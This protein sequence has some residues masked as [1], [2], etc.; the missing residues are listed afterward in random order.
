MRMSSSYFFGPAHDL[1][2]VTLP[3]HTGRT[4]GS[5]LPTFLHTP[6]GGGPVV[7]EVRANGLLVGRCDYQLHLSAP[8]GVNAGTLLRPETRWLKQV[9]VHFCAVEG[10]ALAG[11]ARA[12]QMVP[13]GWMLKTLAAANQSIWYPQAQIAFSTASDN[14]IPVIQDPTPPNGSNGALGDL[15]VWLRADGLEV[16]RVCEQAWELRFPGRRGVPVINARQLFEQ[17][18]TLGVSAGPEAALY[19]AGRK[20]GSGQRGDDLC[21]WPVRLTAADLDDQFVIMPDQ[22]WQTSAA[23][24]TLAHELGHTLFLGHGNGLDDD[25]DG[26]PAGVTG[27][28]RYDEYC[29]PDWLAPP[30]NTDVAEDIGRTPSC[31]LMHVWAC[32]SDLRP[33]Q[34]ETARGVARF[35]PGAVDG[36]PTLQVR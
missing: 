28:R 9:P 19:V 34:V 8:P 7:I 21:G 11:S 14:R 10:S 6:L 15:D 2:T 24:R 3:A 1:G 22:S 26:R 27:P 30:S 12:G 31:S 18:A 25:A 32:S 29:D 36:T 35:A 4:S 16:A 13:A 33:L 17:P 23:V 20:T 5:A